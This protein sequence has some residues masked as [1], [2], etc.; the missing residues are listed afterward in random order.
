MMVIIPE[1]EL[2]AGNLSGSRYCADGGP[3]L[4]GT[5]TLNGMVRIHFVSDGSQNLAG[6]RAEF[7][8]QRNL[9]FRK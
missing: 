1:N 8:I 6:F 5:I 3:L 7:F 4:D 9:I 2:N